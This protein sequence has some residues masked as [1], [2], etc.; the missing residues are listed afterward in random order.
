MRRLD[1]SCQFSGVLVRY[2]VEFPLLELP[3][4]KCHSH[5][6]ICTINLIFD[7]WCW[8][9]GWNRV[10]QISPLENYSFPALSIP[11]SGRK[12]PCVADTERV[13]CRAPPASGWSVYINYLEVFVSSFLFVNLFTRL[14]V[15]V[16][17]QGCLFVLWVIIQYYLISLL[18][19]FQLWLWGALSLG[20][21]DMLPSTS[22]LF[23]TFPYFWHYEILQA[24][25]TPPQS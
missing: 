6:M 15:S 17:I 19:L 7:C 5:I 22:C 20:F 9:T 2:V 14:F 1:R 8:S 11:H 18:K 23:L 12:S 25:F 21:F 13:A 10:C 4:V 24:L 16:W 3:D